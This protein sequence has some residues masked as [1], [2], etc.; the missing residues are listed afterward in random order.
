MFS[1][2]FLYLY[3]ILLIILHIFINMKFLIYIN[4]KELNKSIN[5]LNLFIIQFCDF[6]F[7]F[8]IFLI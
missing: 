2:C 4:K 7:T 8:G 3:L 5:Q 1:D 6:F